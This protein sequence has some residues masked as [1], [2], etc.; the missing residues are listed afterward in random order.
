MGEVFLPLLQRGRRRGP[1][2]SSHQRTA[3]ELSTKKVPRAIRQVIKAAT[4]YKTPIYQGLR[5]TEPSLSC[6]DLPTARF[7]HLKNH[8]DCT[9]NSLP[10]CGMSDMYGYCIMQVILG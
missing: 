6:G 4:R 2:L 9:Q 8:N 1:Q 7:F 10:S 3:A 5:D